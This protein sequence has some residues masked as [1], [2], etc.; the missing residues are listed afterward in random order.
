MDEHL[1]LTGIGLRWCAILGAWD[2]GVLRDLGVAAAE[3]AAIK[4]RGWLLPVAGRPDTWALAAPIRRAALDLIRRERPQIEIEL[5]GRAAAYFTGRLLGAHTDDGRESAE[6]ACISHLA[7][8]HDLFIEYMEWAAIIPY[9]SR[10]QDLQPPR[11]RVACWVEFFA[12]Y[13]D[14]RGEALPA[15]LDRLERLLADGGL[16]PAL[17][18]RALHASH[19]GCISLSRYDQ[20]LDLLREAHGLARRLGD[21]A[22]R[23][24]VLL[25]I[26]QIYNDLY[27]HRRA[28]RLSR[29]SLR[30]ARAE[31]A[32]YREAHALYEVGNNA[33]Q[34]GGWDEAIEALGAAEGMYRQLGMPRR[35]AMV[36]WAQGMIFLAQGDYA[37][38]EQSLRAGLAIAQAENTHNALTAMD[39]LAQLGLLAQVR[40]DDAASLGHFRAAIT[41]TQ[42]H[43]IHHW[44]PILRARVASLLA[45]SGQEAEAEAEW[46]A[47]VAEAEAIRAGIAAEDVRVHLFGT[48]PY[49]YESLVL[50]LL[51]RGRVADAFAYVERA[52]SRAFLDLLTGQGA[53]AELGGGDVGLATIADLQG[54]LELGDV[55]LEYFTTGLRPGDDHWMNAIPRRNRALLRA[56]LAVPATLV[57]VI[58]RDSAEVCRLR[59]GPYDP[60]ASPVE[61]AMAPDLDSNK[62]RPSAHSDDPILDMLRIESQITWLSMRLL[63]PVERQIQGRQRVY[64]IP[65]GTLHYVPFCALHRQGGGYLLDAGGP[66]IIFAPSAS[67]LIHTLR[68]RPAA[69][70]RPSLAIGYNGP[71]ERRLDYAEHEAALVA[72]LIGGNTWAGPE[73]KSARLIGAGR[74][75]RW[76]HIAGHTSFARERPR[77]AGLHLGAGDT[78]DAAQIMGAAGRICRAEM[79][80][81]SACMSG[82]SQ[83]L[84]GDELF[85]LQ[86][87][88]LSA[89]APTMICTLARARDSVALLVMEQLYTRLLADAGLGPAEA[90]RD[91]LVAIRRMTRAEVIAA[92]ARHGYAALIDGGQPDDRPFDQ[93]EFWAPFVVIGRPSR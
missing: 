80:T 12:A 33:M 56:T 38:C 17:R 79:V 6:A 55:V 67:V 18:M 41:I 90:L 42:A 87:A 37:R 10:L 93:P 19:I 62:L 78:L 40:G 8:L 25:S 26:G 46:R 36:C 50:F 9:T 59:D 11:R 89:V 27:D 5:H 91:A 81:L 75:L 70:G 23:S 83:V 82:Y 64:I 51:E 68:A 77:S 71:A 32:T 61:R 76:L 45:R 47:A 3:I 14:L 73:A 7:A 85:G 30:L 58:T 88:F 52:R 4:S 74:R 1:D 84:A 2:L 13:A 34:L 44:R 69:T 92:L 16:D 63:A 66:A 53:D 60:Q 24:Y 86:R 49:I 35:L 20:A 72:G 43:Q 57:F 15:G 39:I 48:T 54:R 31:G 65:H 29:L 22:R 21:R 28:L